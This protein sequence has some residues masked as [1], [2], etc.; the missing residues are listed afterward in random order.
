M[1]TDIQ[2]G[3]MEVGNSIR[4][5]NM[6][7]FTKL[8]QAQAQPI[9]SLFVKSPKTMVWITMDQG[10]HEVITM[11]FSEFIASC[12]SL[13]KH[14]TCY[15]LYFKT[16]LFKDRQCVFEATCRES[17]AVDI[18]KREFPYFLAYMCRKAILADRPFVLDDSAIRYY[19]P[20]HKYVPAL[21]EQ[22]QYC[23]ER[24]YAE[25]AVV[26]KDC[27]MLSGN[28]PAANS[29]RQPASAHKHRERIIRRDVISVSQDKTQEFIR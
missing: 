9:F 27:D 10:N 2:T 7:K 3:S 28:S 15:G 13:P 11:S 23:N 24:V 6:Y 8:L 22:I 21:Q 12:S 16:Y 19:K 29:D 14:S 1:D 4:K 17:L 18:V 26:S 20:L 25:L 5:S